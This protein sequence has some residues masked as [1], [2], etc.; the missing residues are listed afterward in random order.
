M[1]LGDRPF[2]QLVRVCIQAERSRL[3]LES[4]M[5]SHQ[6]CAAA[7]AAYAW[8]ASVS[9]EDYGF[10]KRFGI[11]CP[12]LFSVLLRLW[13]KTW[14]FKMPKNRRE[15]LLRAAALIQIELE[16]IESSVKR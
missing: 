16:E 9:D 11:N 12:L 7:A 5:T 13:P 8:I 3:F 2:A 6:E 10:I 15:S 14:V 1:K 4:E